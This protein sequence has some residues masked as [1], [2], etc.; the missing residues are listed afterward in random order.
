MNGYRTHVLEMHSVPGGL[1]ASWKGKGYTCDGCIH[2][3]AGRLPESGLYPLWEQ[4]GAMPR[5]MLYARELVQ[6]EDPAGNCLTVCTDLDTLA[7]HLKELAPKDAKTFG[8]LLRGT[9]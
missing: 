1:C 6:A 5:P 7:Q 8:E 2:L 4:L 3:L 9:Q